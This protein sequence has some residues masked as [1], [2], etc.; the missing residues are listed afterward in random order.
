MSD[1]GRCCRFAAAC[2]TGQPQARLCNRQTMIP[3][4]PREP[5]VSL[6]A[7]SGHGALLKQ[8]AFRAAKQT[9]G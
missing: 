5:I 1:T 9:R 3:F 2:R 7:E 4:V 8:E 6:M